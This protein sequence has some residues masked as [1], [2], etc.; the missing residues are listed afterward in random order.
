[1][2]HAPTMTT[3]HI[4]IIVYKGSP[5]DYTQ[6]R[7]TA[8]WLRFAD[9]SPSLLAHIIGP[10]GGFIFEWKQSS[11][12]WETQRY[13]KTVDVGCL[14]VAATPTQ[15][16]QALQSTPIKNRDREFNCQTWVE[17]ALKRLKDAG[18]LSEEAYSKGV[19]GMVEA[20]AEAEAEDTEELE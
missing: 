16:V 20:I 7:H 19:D 14:T 4:N 8:L 11:K 15:T 3:V 5:L 2:A 10:L 6:Y 18:F 12:P 1:M 13:A 17:N 9:G